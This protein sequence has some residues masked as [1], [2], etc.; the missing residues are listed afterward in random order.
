MRPV[1]ALLLVGLLV[2]GCLPESAE[3]ITGPPA[4]PPPTAAPTVAPVPRTPAPASPAPP[5]PTITPTASPA[6]PITPSPPPAP[7]AFSINL[8]RDGA[9]VSEY[10]VYY[11]LPAAM[12]VM[13]NI[14]GDGP[15]D[16]SRETQDRLYALARELDGYD[17][18]R[19]VRD[20]EP[21]GW[22]EGLNVEGYGP[23]VV[24][25]EPTLAEAIAVAAR[26]LRLT[27]K[28]VGLLTW[29]GAHSWVMSGFEA[30][31]DPLLW[32]DFEVTAVWIQDVWWPRISTRWGESDPPNTLVPVE[33]LPEDYK[34][35]R[36]PY[37]EFPGKDGMYVMVI[38]LADGS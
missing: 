38:P 11:C 1:T 7:E 37:G 16:T 6:P 3:P 29:R 13:I 4:S 8:Y 20:V 18:P 25:A 12:Q 15:P 32:H 27:G 34:R 28:P 5:P 30:S 35:Y 14:M 33:R 23:Y 19:R 31:A 24:H 17:F 21:E 9:F 2:A 26:Q 10:T 22:A 36:R